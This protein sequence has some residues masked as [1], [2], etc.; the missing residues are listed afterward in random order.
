MKRMGI[1][2]KCGE[3][4]MVQDHHSKGYLPPYEDFTEP[5]CQSCDQKA[6]YKAKRNGRCKL[7][8]LETNKLSINSYSRR[9]HALGIKKQ[10]KITFLE[11]IFKN[12]LLFEELIYNESNGNIY[13]SSYF[14]GCH[15]KLKVINIE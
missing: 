12:I 3:Y 10:R 9:A 15:K 2:K 4:K 13:V 6:H 1:C 14:Q 5:Y 8:P 7:N 11:T